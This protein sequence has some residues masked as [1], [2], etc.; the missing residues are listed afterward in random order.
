MRSALFLL[1]AQVQIGGPR[2]TLFPARLRARTRANDA[3]A[4]RLMLFARAD[5]TA[6]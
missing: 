4:E 1:G 2:R 3:I 6:T 5:R